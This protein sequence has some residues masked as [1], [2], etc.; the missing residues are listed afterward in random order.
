MMNE[1]DI[2]KALTNLVNS[3]TKHITMEQ[4]Y[5]NFCTNVINTVR[6]ATLKIY[7]NKYE[8]ILRPLFDRLGIVYTNEVTK[9]RYNQMIAIQQNQGYKNS[10]INKVMDTLK[11]IF[12]INVELEYI[13]TN[14]IKGIKKL[15]EQEVKIEIITNN[16]KDIIYDYLYKLEL[17]PF[18]LRNITA[19]M[20]LNDTG[21]RINELVNLKLK[22][23]YIEKN[24][25]YVDFTKTG[26]PRYV[27]FTDE[28]KFYLSKYI[29]S[30]E[31]ETE[32]LFISINGTKMRVD[33]VYDFLYKIK[34]EC[35]ITQSISPHKWRH[36]FATSLIEKNVNLHEVMSVLGHTEYSTTKRYLHQK[37]ENQRN[38]ILN[39]IS[40]K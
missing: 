4:A 3:E 27:F 24:I 5:E 11:F 19:I 8:K 31:C 6:P 7:K 32:Y 23:V 22:N 13:S 25:I 40:K 38:D 39:A 16:T 33:S 1:N 36:T 17:N 37:I 9:A 20:L 21:L 12:N 14:P 10:S 34:K 29:T 35:S 18:N 30:I 28:T 2:L 15:K 26:K